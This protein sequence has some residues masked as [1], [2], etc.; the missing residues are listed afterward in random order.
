MQCQHQQQ[1][2]CFLRCWWW[3]LALRTLPGGF[4][5]SKTLFFKKKIS[6]SWLVWVRVSIH[7]GRRKPSR[8]LW[9][10]P[11]PTK[12]KSRFLYLVHFN[13][14][15]HKSVSEREWQGARPA[16][17]SGSGYSF[18][19][20]PLLPIS[21]SL[22]THLLLETISDSCFLSLTLLCDSKQ[23][24][25]SICDSQPGVVGFHLHPRGYVP[26][27]EDTF[28]CYK[29][30]RCLLSSGQRSGMLLNTLQSQD[31]PHPHHSKEWPSP[32]RQCCQGQHSLVYQ[33]V[34]VLVA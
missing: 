6:R 33:K 14:W 1:K 34:K 17:P 7:N 30:G 27:S 28:G 9:D 11:E 31:N 21:P 32:K 12:W 15:L 20:T 24:C 16:E 4:F 25:L 13:D 8:E 18:S 10:W 3:I 19:N 22:C 5:K 23:S 2:Y 26:K 29:R